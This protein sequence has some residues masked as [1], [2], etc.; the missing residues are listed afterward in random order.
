MSYH[1]WLQQL[2]RKAQSRSFFFGPEIVH[3]DAFCNAVL[4]AVKLRRIAVLVAR[5]LFA[6]TSGVGH[7]RLGSDGLPDV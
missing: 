5:L 4:H 1:S 7:L 6:A 2:H 3:S